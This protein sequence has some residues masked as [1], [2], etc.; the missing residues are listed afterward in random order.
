MKKVLGFLL[1][2]IPVWGEPMKKLVDITDNFSHKYNENKI[3]FENYSS[4]YEKERGGIYEHDGYTVLIEGALK[5]IK[6]HE[7]KQCVLIIEDLDRIDPAHL[8]RILNVLGAH[9]DRPNFTANK[10]GFDKIVTVFDYEVTKHIFHH[11]YGNNANYNGYINKFISIH[12]FHYSIH[13]IAQDFLKSYICDNCLLNERHLSLSRHAVIENEAIVNL[14]DHIGNM[15]VRDV[16]HILS[17]IDQEK[18]VDEVELCEGTKVMSTAPI[19]NLLIVLKRMGLKVSKEWVS[20]YLLLCGNKEILNIL[21]VF[22]LNDVRLDSGDYF[23]Y[24]REYWRIRKTM[25]KDN[26][27]IKCEFLNNTISGYKISNIDID[28]I[29]E[30]AL[31]LAYNYI[32]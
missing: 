16:V 15:S 6:E 4:I 9:I 21:G 19:I 32:K 7:S 20:K 14:K 12:P 1:A 30:K 31:A 25:N 29:T 2:S 10:F 17:G 22:L 26:V 24:K 23:E 13:G 27:V 18:N 3:T 8:F 11:F 5:Y 28:K